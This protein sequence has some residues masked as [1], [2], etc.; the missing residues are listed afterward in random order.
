MVHKILYEKLQ[1][2]FH[3]PNYLYFMVSLIL[4]LIVPAVA[5]MASTTGTILMEATYGFVILMAAIYTT[6]NMRELT[7][8]SSL[9]GIVFLLFVI[10]NGDIPPHLSWINGI[11]TFAFFLFVLW[12]L[13]KFVLRA[14]EVDAN[15]V[16]ACISGY[17]VLGIVGAPL[18]AMINLS[19][20]H[21]FHLPDHSDFY[22]FIYFSFV[23]LTT[24]GY[25]DI[26]PVHPFSKA[27]SLVISIAGQLYLTFLVAIIVGKYL[28][29]QQ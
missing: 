16:F 4:L 2:H 27:I 14:K 7:I 21:A 12:E 9:G 6:S 24:V 10:N 11:L 18:C 26:T 3:H 20:D 1:Y 13:L 19:I 28:M 17:L 5:P 29:Y 8:A 25:G 15:V 22:D 23:T